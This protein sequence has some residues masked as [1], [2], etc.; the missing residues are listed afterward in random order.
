MKDA[1]VQVIEYDDSFYSDILANADV[2]KLYS[3]IDSQTNGLSTTMLDELKKT[4]K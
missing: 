1:G 4:E 2:Q 3:D